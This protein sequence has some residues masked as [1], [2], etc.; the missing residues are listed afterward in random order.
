MKYALKKL[1]ESATRAAKW[2]GHDLK[3]TRGQYGSGW[4]GGDVRYAECRKCGEWVMVKTKTAPNDIDCGG[5]AVAVDC[6]K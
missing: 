4:S 3:W 5:P 1:K 2:R 6:Q